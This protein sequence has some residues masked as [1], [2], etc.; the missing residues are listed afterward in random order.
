MRRSRSSASGSS[1]ASVD[2]RVS[3]E[4][5]SR[6]IT[7]GELALMARSRNLKSLAQSPP[8]H[9]GDRTLDGVS[10]DMHDIAS[11][12]D[13]IA[14]D[15]PSIFQPGSAAKS[16]H[17]ASETRF[18]FE[19][20][21]NT[22]ESSNSRGWCNLTVDNL[23]RQ[24]QSSKLRLRVMAVD[25]SP[26]QGDLKVVVTQERQEGHEPAVALLRLRESNDEDESCLWRLR[27]EDEELRIW[28][29][30]LLAN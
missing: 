22:L 11:R 1:R 24:L 30:Q 23:V 6:T 14:F 20:T 26:F 21:W 7:P 8:I 16:D 2:S 3:S 17:H 25:Q 18:E 15:S 19:T 12:A 29:G 28:V 4:T 13:L 10:S 9:S 5:M 27:C